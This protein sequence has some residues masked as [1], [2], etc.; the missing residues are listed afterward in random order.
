MKF[1]VLKN[2]CSS[3]IIAGE[4]GGCAGK[5]PPHGEGG[6]R[7]REGPRGRGHHGHH[8]GACCRNFYLY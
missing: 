6:G 7:G 4:G 2:Q 8:W 1:K 5:G 3:E